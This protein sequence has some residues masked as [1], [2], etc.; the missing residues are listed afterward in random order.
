MANE[1]LHDL[2]PNVDRVLDEFVAD[3]RKIFDHDLRAIVLF[4]SA[5]EA[6]LRPTSDVNLLLVLTRFEQAKADKLREPFRIA[7]T[8]VQLRTMFLLADEVEPA[9]KAFAV[10][11]ADI[12]RRRRVL[13]G[14]DPFA[15][16]SVSREDAIVR[17][18]QTLL[19]LTLRLREMYVGRG[20]REEQLAAV[21][22]NMAG[23]LRSCAAT[24]LE[25]EG[26]PAKSAKEALESVASSMPEANI[27]A[28]DLSRISEARQNRTLEPGV[29]GAT[30]FHLIHLAHAMWK[31]ALNLS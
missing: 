22:A 17:L 19:N 31:R 28:Q 18:K 25:L 2:P 20:L 12:L 15:G 9:L 4:G 3:A 16:L 1:L 29:A 26:N 11:F 6:K 21:I 7:Q 30:F 5:A 24:L 23:P 14:E 10:K 13:Y 27:T 8:A